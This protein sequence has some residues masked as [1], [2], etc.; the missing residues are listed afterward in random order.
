MTRRKILPLLALLAL[1]SSCSL[2]GD[3]QTAAK[4]GAEALRPA[5]ASLLVNYRTEGQACL[6]AASSRPEADACFSELR[7]AWRVWDALEPIRATMDALVQIEGEWQEASDRRWPPA[8][9]TACEIPPKEP[10]P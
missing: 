10:R 2:F 8:V 6:A 9:T 4:A 7:A 5:I 3:P 1:L